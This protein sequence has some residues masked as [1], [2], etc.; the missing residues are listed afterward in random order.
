MP[1]AN[2]DAALLELIVCP[3]CHAA[4]SVEGSELACTGCDLVYPI[5]DGIPVLLIDRAHRAGEQDT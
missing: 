3:S 5:V 2:V 1:E 4:L